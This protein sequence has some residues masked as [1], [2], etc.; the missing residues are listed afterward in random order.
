MVT[1]PTNWWDHKL[2]QS[3]SFIDGVTYEVSFWAKAGSL[4]GSDERMYMI[5][6][7]LSTGTLVFNPELTTSW[8][9]YLRAG[10][11]N[12]TIITLNNVWEMA[13]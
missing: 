6:N 10:R 1:A 2:Y 11:S 8:V 13:I 5:D 9:K 3:I 4:D 7:G 12:T